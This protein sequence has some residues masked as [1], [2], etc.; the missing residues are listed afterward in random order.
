M[1]RLDWLIFKSV[2][3]AVILT[4][5]IFAGFDT[6]LA[7]LNE[8]DEIGIGDY[9]M[10]RVLEYVALTVPRRL[11]QMF[12]TAAVVG[13]ML[14]LGSLAARSELIALQ[15]AGASRT[16]IA[17][18]GVYAVAFLMV[19]AL[20]LGEWIGPRA[21][22][23][24]ADLSAQSKSEGIAFAGSGLWLRDGKAV[25]NAKRIVITGPGKIELW[26]V[27]RYQFGTNARLEEVIKAER[28]SY[29]A[30]S[31]DM[32]NLTRDRLSDEQVSSDKQE[33]LKVDTLLDPGLI[34]ANSVRPRLQG[35]VDLLDTM[36]YAQV[37]QLDGMAFES[38]FWFRVFYPLVSLALAFAAAP[39]AFG[40]LRSGGQGQRLLLGMA[41]GIA[42]YFAQR[43]LINLAETNRDGLILVNVLPPVL[44][45]VVTIWALRRPAR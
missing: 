22:R 37:N 9:D 4:C 18:S 36:R 12:S 6:L 16:R 32:L 2:V 13:T 15:A 14:G 40:S 31:I 42:F 33:S 39:F 10:S 30:G 27:W 3:P 43:T 20:L 8:L 35:T 25:W 1:S 24:A 34:E 7:L 26:E 17:L 38:A 45:I 23:M 41:F 29:S 19:F 44:L 28:A 21:D 11:Y 5:V